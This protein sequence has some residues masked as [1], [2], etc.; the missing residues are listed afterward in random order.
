MFFKSHEIRLKNTE[1]DN[2]KKIGT[3]IGN[4]NTAEKL[5]SDKC[6]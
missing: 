5:C 4:M 6:L 2:V 3:K 1:F